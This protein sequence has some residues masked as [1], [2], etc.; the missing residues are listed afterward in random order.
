MSEA[1]FWDNQERAQDIVQQVKILA[2]TEPIPND[3]L[4]F[5][6]DFPAE[7]RTQIVK[8]GTEGF[9]AWRAARPANDYESFRP[10]LERQIELRKRYVEL[11]P[12]AEEPYDVLLDDYERGM[13]ASEV[14]VVFERCRAEKQYVA[15]QSGDWRDC[16][17]RRFTRMAGRAPG[18]SPESR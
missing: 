3:T 12:E 2:L 7:L 13:K 6:P 17:P 5:A 4:S 16:A 1:G 9:M 11:F 18:P 8:A 14:R 10:H 15:S